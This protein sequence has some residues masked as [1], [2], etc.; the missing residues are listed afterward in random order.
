MRIQNPFSLPPSCVALELVVLLCSAVL[1]RRTIIAA[2]RGDPHE[3]HVFAAALAYGVLMELVSFTFLDNYWHAQFVIMLYRGKLPLYVVALY[4][5][6]LHGAHAIVRRIGLP[7]WAEPLVVGLAIVLFDA[8]FD[9]L[10]PDA[11]WW[12]WSSTDPNLGARW[13]GVPLTSYYWHLAF[14]AGFALLVRTTQRFVRTPARALLLAPIVGALT[15]VLGAIAFVPFHLLRRVGVSDGANLA[16]LGAVSVAV[17]LLGKKRGAREPDRALWLTS[18][19]YHAF[20]VIVAV[21]LYA[22]AGVEQ[23]AV[24]ALF[25]AGATMLSL[26]LRGYALGFRAEGRARVATG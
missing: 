20:F 15:I 6:F 22:R 9:V 10:G 11:R 25:V 16:L 4:P 14:G 12:S 1:L 18:L 17:L 23:A 21:A 13:L 26:A 19:G 8:P 24:K 7:A 2:R 3:L 5:L